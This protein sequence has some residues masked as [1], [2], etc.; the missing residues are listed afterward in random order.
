MQ[1]SLLEN[2]PQNVSAKLYFYENG[3]EIGSRR[4]LS[5]SALLGLTLVLPRSLGI[6]AARLTLTSEGG[7]PLLVQSLSLIEWA[8]DSEAWGALLEPLPS[9]A[10]PLC[11]LHIVVECPS[12]R[13]YGRMDED[14]EF[15]LCRDEHC[16]RAV[17]LLLLSECELCAPLAGGSLY[18]LPEEAAAQ[19]SVG[20][21]DSLFFTLSSLGVRGVYLCPTPK[22]GARGPGE[23]PSTPRPRAFISAAR[24]RGLCVL[25]DFLLLLGVTE[26]PD[27]L[28][29]GF[30]SPSS[31]HAPIEEEPRPAFWELPLAPRE[32]SE[33]SLAEYCGEDGV[34]AEALSFGY[35][36][37]VA[38]AADC[39]GD[40]F[41]SAL[42][43]AL[44]EAENPLLLGATEAGGVSIAFGARRRF[45]FGDELDAPI[46]YALRTAL[47]DFFLGKRTE[48]LAC[49][50]HATLASLPPRALA[51]IPNLLSDGALGYFDDALATAI[52]D[53]TP[54]VELAYLVAATLP[55]V[56]AYFAGEEARATAT[57]RHLALLRRKE[58]TYENGGF[59]LLHLSPTLFAFAREGEGES[60]VTLVNSSD[61]P[62]T[63]CSPDEFFV[64]YGGRGRKQR[65]T[66]RPHGGAVLKI[67]LWTGESCRLDFSHT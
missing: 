58:P 15:T 53:P 20:D 51:S 12:Y 32:A 33:G 5:P 62:L 38:R 44:K 66:L 3:K 7:E 25:A 29:G 8:G 17:S 1:S 43:G 21:A 42:R 50:C 61:A 37:L 22:G 31:P 2:I 56:P 46:S 18:C 55:G 65:V 54:Y 28:F 49:Y 63:V 11:H 40:A 4:V 23:D 9:A 41:L 48:R 13:L 60:L 34:I 52:S 27:L 30:C 59:R 14:G 36:G 39:F 45:F 6:T 26:H 47:L 57:L 16:E 10:M 35:N 19:M 24:E 64:I 67:P